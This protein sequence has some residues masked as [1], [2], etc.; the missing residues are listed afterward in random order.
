MLESW[1]KRI[2][3]Q[4]RI[5]GRAN[6]RPIDS[7][8]YIYIYMPVLCQEYML[9]FCLPLSSQP[10]LNLLSTQQQGRARRG[11]RHTGGARP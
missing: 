9:F 1:L 7:S 10:K 5:N 2:Q 3:V 11:G 6:A 8:I 4:G